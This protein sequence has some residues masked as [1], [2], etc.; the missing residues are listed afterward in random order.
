MFA[1]DSYVDPIKRTKKL[2]SDLPEGQIDFNTNIRND[3]LSYDPK[4]TKLFIQ[5]VPEHEKVEPKWY[6]KGTVKEFSTDHPAGYE[7]KY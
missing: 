5:P 2:H 4:S 7:V 3:I 1:N 6:P